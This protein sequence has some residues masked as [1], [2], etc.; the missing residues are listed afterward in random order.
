MLRYQQAAGNGS[1]SPLSLDQLQVWTRPL[2]DSFLAQVPPNTRD[3]VVALL[4]ID[5]GISS[6]NFAELNQWSRHSLGNRFAKL[7]RDTRAFASSLP[8][9]GRLDGLRYGGKWRDAQRY[10]K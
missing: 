5:G 8:V 6:A 1:G 7:K 3:L 2:V 10:A 4:G 9:P